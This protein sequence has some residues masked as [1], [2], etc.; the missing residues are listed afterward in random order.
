MSDTTVLSIAPDALDMIRQLRDNEP[1]DEEF[2][3]SI[4]VTGFRG[5]QF[6]YELAFV[7]LSDKAE[8]WVLDS[9]NR[10]PWD[11]IAYDLITATGKLEENPA[12]AYLIEGRNPL[13]VTDLTDLSS[14]YFLGV[15]LNCAQCHDHKYDP[16][17]QQEFYQLFA[18]FDNIP[19]RGLVYNFGNDEPTIQALNRDHRGRDAPTDVLSFPVDGTGPAAGPRE[20]GDVVICEAHTADVSEA[21]VHG[22]LRENLA[23]N[24]VADRVDIHAAALGARAGRTRLPRDPNA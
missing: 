14:R 23:A 1:G 9:F 19:E 6:S 12:V 8:N 11:K 4:E 2:A 13:G 7:P 20:L 10:D 15:R 5:P 18:Y 24:G 21:A 17:T 16:L 22:V 3:L